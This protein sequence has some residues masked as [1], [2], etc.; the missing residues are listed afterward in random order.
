MTERHSRSLDS[1]MTQIAVLDHHPA[2]R[3]LR[4][5]AADMV[6]SLP[7]IGELARKRATLGA[8]TG[9]RILCRAS[10]PNRTPP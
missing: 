7:F 1:L 3:H 8:I 10:S 2:H 5:L 6:F 4:M 9:Y